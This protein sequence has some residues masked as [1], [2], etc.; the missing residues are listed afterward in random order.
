M[1]GET[2]SLLPT[3]EQARAIL[4]TLPGLKMAGKDGREES[5]AVY[6]ETIGGRAPTEVPPCESLHGGGGHAQ[7]VVVVRS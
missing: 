4:A 2:G 3:L 5:A 1:W 7:V 6:Y